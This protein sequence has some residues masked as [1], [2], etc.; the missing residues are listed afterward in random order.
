MKKLVTFC[1]LLLAV[2]VNAGTNHPVKTVKVQTPKKP[3]YDVIHKRIDN[4]IEKKV[5][6]VVVW[7][8][9]AKAKG[10]L[11]GFNAD[12]T[13]AEIMLDKNAS[14]EADLAGTDSYKIKVDLSTFAKGAYSENK[15]AGKFLKSFNSNGQNLY[16]YTFDVNPKGNFVKSA[17]NLNRISR[18]QAARLLK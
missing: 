17:S 11:I 9:G 2:A 18:E 1:A 14:L 12:K 15:Q 5:R 16:V 4:A 10:A 13:K 7:V 6:V 8:N 3:A